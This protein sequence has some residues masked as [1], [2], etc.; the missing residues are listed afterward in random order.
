MVLFKLYLFHIS[1]KKLC[2]DVDTP[3]EEDVF[4]KVTVAHISV[5]HVCLSVSVSLA[6]CPLFF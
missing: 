6:L 4:S 3:G 5:V 2:S 1:G